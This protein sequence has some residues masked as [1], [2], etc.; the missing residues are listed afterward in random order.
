METNTGQFAKEPTMFERRSLIRLGLV[1]GGSIALAGGLA[2]CGSSATSA[3]KAGATAGA[4]KRGG[5]LILATDT[6]TTNESMD[7]ALS[8]NDGMYM[9]QGCI[10]EG[11]AWLDENQVPHP[12]LATWT[13][14]HDFS[15][16]TLKVRPG[17]TFHDGTP[18]TAHDIEWMILRNLDPK[19]G[20][21]LQSR[22]AA[23]LTT[24]GVKVVDDNTLTLTCKQPD[25][26]LMG[27][28]G[29]VAAF[30]VPK[31]TTDFNSG[32]G[33]GAYVLKSYTPGQG[34]E[35]TANPD[36]W[37]KDLP[38][39]DGVRC[40]QVPDSAT[41]VQ[42]VLSGQTHGTE[43]DYQ[44]VPTVKGSSNA[45]MYIAK[46]AALLN[47]A[48]DQTQKPF[49]DVRVRQAVKLCVDRDKALQV[50]YAGYGEATADVPIAASDPQFPASFKSNM[51][52]DFAKAK[53]LLTQ[54]GYPNGIKL[55]LETPSDS[56]HATFALAMATA[57]KGSPVTITVH[58]SDPSTYWD[59]LWEHV[60]FMTNDWNHRAPIELMPLMFDKTAEWNETKF[61]DDQFEH[62]IDVARRTQGPSQDSAIASAAQRVLD[63]SGFICPG[64]RH[65]IFAFKKNVNQATYDSSTSL[66]LTKAW[67]S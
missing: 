53:D 18:L 10:R 49:D 11:V 47:L 12:Q 17:V 19:S 23:S 22:L 34:F 62:Y 39:L 45:T 31:G 33:T 59:K 54:A 64:F 7:P 61:N 4:V 43:I 25:S 30:I 38:Y 28:F 27:P 63:T 8:I 60:P 46:N 56:L 40:L 21:S 50:A 20:S 24:S 51:S 2:A 41:R 13:A 65:R 9:L 44:S 58:Q 52:Q 57:V 5:T 48:M 14:N 6:L 35:V 37:Q 3:P 15:K 16:W 42:G 29:R 1:A 26:A 66:N 36:Y 67:L 32:Q 55:T